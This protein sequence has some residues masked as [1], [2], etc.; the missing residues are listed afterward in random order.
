MTPS[1]RL[2]SAMVALKM[3][4]PARQFFGSFTLALFKTLNAFWQVFCAVNAFALEAMRARFL[5]ALREI[6]P[7][8]IDTVLGLSQLNLLG[9]LH[10]FVFGT[11]VLHELF[12]KIN[13][14]VD[15][16]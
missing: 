6:S 16:A 5:L 8:K 12:D 14:P 13:Q 7:V 15:A 4:W 11:D 2:I 3:L 10:L 9:F 1:S